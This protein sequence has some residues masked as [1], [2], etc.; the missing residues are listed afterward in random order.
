M[1]RIAG[2]IGTSHVPAIGLAIERRQQSEPYW[3]PFFDGYPPVHRWLE[4]IRPDVAVIFYNDHGLNFFLDKLPTFAVG[5]A[6]A[7]PTADEGWGLKPLAPFEGDAELSWHVIEALVANDFDVT[8]CQEMKLDHGATNPMS[9]LWPGSDGRWP[10]RLLPIHVN[11]VQ[12][13]LPSPARC[14]RFG[15]VVGRALQ[16]YPQDLTVVVIGSGGLSHQLEGRRAGFINRDFDLMCLEKIVAEPEALT[17]YSARDLVRLAG[18]Q[19]V[20][21]LCWLMMRGALTGTVKRLHANYHIPIS[22]TAAATL[23]LEHA[24]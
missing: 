15:Q 1:A 19:G 7:Y 5:A 20:E 11:T 18:S 21:L 22:N 3:K 24:A 10:V 23:L 13:P 2:A 9:L 16:S 14:L 17:G 6:A 12:H 4:R 8:T